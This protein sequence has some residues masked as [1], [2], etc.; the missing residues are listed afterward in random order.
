MSYILKNKDSYQTLNSYLLNESIVP[1]ATEYGT[2]TTRDNKEIN[3]YDGFM[4]SFFEQDKLYY[5]VA[6][7]TTTGEVG[8][9]VTAQHTDNVKEYDDSRV[10]S[11]SPVKVFGKVF[12]VLIELIK[13]SG[14]NM[15]QF[16]SANFALGKMYDKLV[17]NKYFLQS[18]ENHNFEY[19]GKIDEKY[20]FKKISE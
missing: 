18:L 9:G 14:V 6:L 12:Y 7:D 16:D 10:L 20:V 11:K 17:K 3:E 4:V 19:H 8:F 5:A 15:I 1:V 2:N 13:K